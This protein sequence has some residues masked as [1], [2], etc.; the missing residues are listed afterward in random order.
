[1]NLN[2]ILLPVVAAGSV[3]ATTYGSTVA[4]QHLPE[5]VPPVAGQIGLPVLAF[6]AGYYLHK[7]TGGPMKAVGTGLQISAALSGLAAIFERLRG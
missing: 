4:M 7:R 2:T 6:T 5:S 1:M 3:M